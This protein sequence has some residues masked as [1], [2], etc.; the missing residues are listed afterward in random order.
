MDQSVSISPIQPERHL[1]KYDR[2]FPYSFDS[3][4]ILSE[5]VLDCIVIINNHNVASRG[6]LL[7]K[8]ETS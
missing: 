3:N 5:N 1:A 2:V 8:M 7:F 6:V 4:C